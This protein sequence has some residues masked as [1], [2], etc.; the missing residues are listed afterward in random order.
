MNNPKFYTACPECGAHLDHG[1]V[2]DCKRAQADG[3]ALAVIEPPDID[4]LIVIEQLPVIKEQ[5]AAMS[6]AIDGRVAAIMALEVTEDN[7]KEMK[8]LRADFRKEFDEFETRRKA[9]KTAVTRPYDDFNAAYEQHIGGKYKPADKQI[10]DKIKSVENTLKARDKARIKVYF[11]EC[12]SA[13][14]VTDWVD[15]ERFHANQPGSTS[16][17]GYK[18]NAKEYC[19]RIASDLNVITFIL[20]SR[21][22]KALSNLIA[23]FSKIMA[24]F[25]S[26]LSA[27]RLLLLSAGNSVRLSIE[28][29]GT[30]S[31]SCFAHISL[32]IAT[33]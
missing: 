11:D 6:A 32:K 22:R 19:G 24:K 15:F 26:V 16:E 1:E 31:R 18:R 12:T 29:V 9:V 7:L 13:L 10:A 27:P 28:S 8:K 14:N 4:A 30:M 17:P 5:L 23:A 3:T 20:Y 25:H 2:C 33:Q 21:S